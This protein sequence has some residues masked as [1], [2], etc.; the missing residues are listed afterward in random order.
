MKLNEKSLRL[1]VCF[2]RNLLDDESSQDFTQRMTHNDDDTTFSD[3]LF[4]FANVKIP[5]R[6]EWRIHQKV[7]VREERRRS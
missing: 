1:C 4:V 5:S 6:V 7:Q 3:I 2:P